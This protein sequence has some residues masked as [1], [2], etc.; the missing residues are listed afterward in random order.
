MASNLTNVTNRSSSGRSNFSTTELF[1]FL[2]L[3]ETEFGKR[4]DAMKVINVLQKEGLPSRAYVRLKTM[5]EDGEPFVRI[6]LK[7]VGYCSHSSFVHAL[8]KCGY[9][10]IADKMEHCIGTRGNAV[11]F[12]ARA[13]VVSKIDGSHDSALALYFSI[14]RNVDNA[15][16]VDKN[17]FLKMKTQQLSSELERLDPELTRRRSCLLDKLLVAYCVSVE[18]VSDV[19]SRLE[20]VITKLYVNANYRKRF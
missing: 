14:K 20:G 3:V 4:Y 15:T 6:M 12:D 5:Y 1:A 10:D 17:E 16:F 9:S 7:A 2:E 18:V 13:D 8:Y 11:S 19:S